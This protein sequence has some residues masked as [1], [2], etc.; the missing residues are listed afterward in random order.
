MFAPVCCWGW[1][2]DVNVNLMKALTS[3]AAGTAATAGLVRLIYFAPLPSYM[4]FALAVVVPIPSI[5][6]ALVLVNYGP[7]STLGKTGLTGDPRELLNLFLYGCLSA[8]AYGAVARAWRI[9]HPTDCLADND[10]ENEP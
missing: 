6:I 5:A 8:L 9:F 10:T 1:S 2:K 4:K 3:F 7:G